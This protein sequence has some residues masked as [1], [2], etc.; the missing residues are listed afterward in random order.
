[1]SN[2]KFV[3]ILE[4]SGENLSV[5]K[6]ND[7]YVLEGVFAQFGV[8]NNNHRIYEEKEYLPHMEYLKKKISENRLLGELDHPEKFDI[9]LNK[10]SHLI[11][12]IRYDAKKRQV[13]GKIKLLDTPSGQI[14]KNLVDSGIPI[15]ISSRAAGVVGEN[16]KVQIKRIFTYDLV[17]D[18]GFENAQMKRINES[19]GYGEDDQLAIYDMSDKASLVFMESL[20]S[21]EINKAN[22]EKTPQKMSEFVTIDDMNKYSLIIK[23]EIEKINNRLE[24]ISESED[25]ETKIAALQEEVENLKQYASYLAEEQNK[26]IGYANYLAEKVNQGI[27]YTEHVAE[28]ADKGIAYTE[29]VAERADKGIQYAESISEKLGQ[30]IEYQNYLAEKQNQGLSYAEYLAEKLGQTIG[31]AEHIAEHA[32]NSIRYSEY[33]AE[34]AATK[35]DFKALTE[36]AEYI[37][38]GVNGGTVARTNDIN[39]EDDEKKAKEDKGVLAGAVKESRNVME[40]YSALDE[41]I[42][43]V[44]ESIEKQR[45]E[46]N[47]LDKTYPYV[48]FLGEEKLN[49]FTSLSEADKMRVTNAYNAKPAYDEAG[50]V[51]VWETALAKTE[52]N[53]A[54][55]TSIPAEYLPLWE[56]ASS[57]V[58]ERITRQAKVYNL[59]TEYQIKNFWQT[60]GLTPTYNAEA[61]AINENAIA[62]D[63][64]AVDE[65]L[66]K[67]GYTESYI[68]SIKKGLGRY[69]NQR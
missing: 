64:P 47:S 24:K 25:K 44:L 20:E 21:D 11:E 14:A 33:L 18:P 48:K 66:A 36:Y 49:A 60:R 59:S 30:S 22:T 27:E 8:E 6:S 68:E 17:A 55:L 23:E 34:N 15:S 62:N 52:V 54:W 45:M 12:D 42:K 32:D 5:S 69:N 51:K 43:N 40:R 3:M 67:L 50:I 37:A 57:D 7:D 31:Y 46:S 9:S 65:K 2:K 10:V 63:T 35:E 41:K 4:R 39:E 28:K 38:E 13:V 58:K 26:A 29:H 19:L 1:M 53:E 16:K 56:S 61:G